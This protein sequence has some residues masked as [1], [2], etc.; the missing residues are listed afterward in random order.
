MG[1][2]GVGSG[3]IGQE[4][5]G[6]DWLLI[7]TAKSHSIMTEQVLTIKESCCCLLLTTKIAKRLGNVSFPSR[8]I[9][10]LGHLIQIPL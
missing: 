7:A 1:G 9:E 8:S 10:N 2:L 3:S 6:V 5:K 4:I